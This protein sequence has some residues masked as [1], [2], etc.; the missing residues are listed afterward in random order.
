MSSV[1]DLEITEGVAI[2]ETPE[3][4]ARQMFDEYDLN[5]D[6]TLSRAELIELF[7][8]LLPNA[9]ISRIQRMAATADFDISSV[10]RIGTSDAS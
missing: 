10:G 3:E 1:G 9:A 6:G 4:E 5:G 2:E 8:T 7:K